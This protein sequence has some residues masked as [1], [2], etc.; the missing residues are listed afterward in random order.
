MRMIVFFDLPTETA[1]DRRTYHQFRKMLIRNGF[2]MMQE[3]VY[4]K[5]LLNSSAVE[6]EAENIRKKRPEKG[7]VQLMTIT[8]KQFSEIEYITGKFY[9]E[10]ISTDERT[11]I[12]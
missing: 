10:V 8:E 6:L 9:S 3:S 2:I 12:L 5:L 1:E 11:V 4:C 7:I